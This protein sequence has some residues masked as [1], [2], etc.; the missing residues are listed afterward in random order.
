MADVAGGE[1]RRIDAKF[2]KRGGEQQRW[3]AER[4]VGEAEGS[5]VHADCAA[6]TGIEENLRRFRRVHVHRLHELARLIGADGNHAEIDG[7]MARADFAESL[8]IAAVPCMPESATTAI[9]QPTAPVGEVAVVKR[10]CREMLRGRGGDVYATAEIACFMP[11]DV[12]RVSKTFAAQPSGMAL[13]NQQ[14]WFPAELA[15]GC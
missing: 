3:F 10:T 11:A 14:T 9:Y 7:A 5:P 1:G 15:Q 12:L 6:T 8:A 13:R 2:L 4:F